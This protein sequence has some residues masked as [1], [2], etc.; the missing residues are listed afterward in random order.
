MY[1]L[2]ASLA[3]VEMRLA[4]EE[5][6]KERMLTKQDVE[7]YLLQA[8][9]S[10]AKMLVELLIDKV[11]LYDDKIE[12]TYKYNSTDP[13]EPEKEVRRDLLLFGKKIKITQRSFTVLFEL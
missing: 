9:H 7:A 6:K 12:I 5:N 8:L 1:K 2:E 13:D 11:I 10:D 3:A 4:A